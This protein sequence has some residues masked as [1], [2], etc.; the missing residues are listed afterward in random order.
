MI[1]EDCM[2]WH[3]FIIKEVL[4]IYQARTEAPIL[5]PCQLKLPETIFQ[6][7]QCQKPIKRAHEWKNINEKATSVVF[8]SYQQYKH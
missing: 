6:S 4:T 1:I 3:Y 2:A 8:Y 7:S 5:S